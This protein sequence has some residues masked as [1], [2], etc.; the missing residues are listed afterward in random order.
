MIYLQVNNKVLIV[1]I[2][3]V[4]GPLEV[5]EDPS[6]SRKLWLH[7]LVMEET[8][9]SVVPINK[10]EDRTFMEVEELWLQVR[11]LELFMLLLIQ[12]ECVK[13][14]LKVAEVAMVVQLVVLTLELGIDVLFHL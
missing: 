7:L 9:Y 10:K 8:K 12:Q 14:L 4:L 1:S 11:I 13:I 3:T 6:G 2:F 5:L